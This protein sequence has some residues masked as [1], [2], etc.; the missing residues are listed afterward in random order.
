M[1]IAIIPSNNGMGHL[2]RCIDLSN[3]LINKYSVDLF[4]DAKKSK[5]FKINKY[6]K[7]IN[8]QSS[9]ISNNRIVNKNWLNKFKKLDKNYNLY[10]LDS[11]PEF[12]FYKKNFILL[13][14]FFFHR[15]Y[16]LSNEYYLRLEKLLKKHKIYIFGNYLFIKDY[17]K[18]F[19]LKKIGFIGKKKSVVTYKNNTLL[20]FG[21]AHFKN[22][23][24]FEKSVSLILDQ[25]KF[26]NYKILQ[27]LRTKDRIKIFSNIGMVICKPGLG[28]ISDAIKNNIFIVAILNKYM[29]QEF[30]YN[31]SIIKKK[32]LGLVI[33][34][35]SQLKKV[36]QKNLNIK[37]KLSIIKK[38]YNKLKFEG[39]KEIFKVLKSLK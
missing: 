27:N 18:D 33:D 20:S 17:L 21:G 38:N 31:A 1:K 19:R 9:R 35:M 14:N 8:F 11:L 37:R 25:Y 28:I 32:K 10:I 26:K 39:E 6:I 22:K 34:D 15:E 30:Y 12:I 7:I 3:K 13:A 24:K 36:L 16:F 5:F 23:K 4:C 29:N 2:K